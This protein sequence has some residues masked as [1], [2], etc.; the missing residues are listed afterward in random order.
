M[1][2]YNKDIFST[3]REMPLPPLSEDEYQ[4]RVEYYN[5]VISDYRLR[6]KKAITK[7]QA[8]EF[9][10]KHRWFIDRDA[11][12]DLDF[13][14]WKLLLNQMVVIY[15]HSCVLVQIKYTGK[16]YRPDGWTKEELDEKIEILGIDEPGKYDIYREAGYDY[17]KPECLRKVAVGA[18]S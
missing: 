11:M 9:E 6:L 4:K 13:D 10:K 8:A 14:T 7:R 12:L 3:P 16:R 5:T 1:L 15:S 18:L 2:L 17:P